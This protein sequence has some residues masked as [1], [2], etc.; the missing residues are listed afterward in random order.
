MCPVSLPLRSSLLVLV[1]FLFVVSPARAAAASVPRST[2]CWRVE[3]LRRGM[4]GH[5]RTVMKGTRVE[6]FQVEVLGVL[7]NTSPGRDLV[8]A[9]LSGLGLEKTGVIAG[10]SGSPV[11]IEGKLLGAVAY[12]WPFGKEPIAGITPFGQMQGFVEALQRSDVAGRG[13]GPVRVGL[14]ERLRAGGKEFSAVTVAQDHDEPA[15]RDDDALLLRPLRSPLVAS[16]FGPAALKLLAREAGKF[17][18]V[19]MQGGSASARIADE[20][21]DAVLEPGGPLAVSLIT[22]DFDL[23]GI[24]TVTHV[25]GNRVYGWGHPFMSLGDCGLPMMTGYIHTIYPRQTVSFKM[26]SPLREVGVMHADVSTCIA[27]AT[28][29]KADLLPVHMSVT[30]GK[31]DPRTF[32]VQVARHSALLPS[33]VFTSLVNCIDL[34]GELPDE[35]TAHLAARIEVEGAAPIVIEDT[36]SGFSGARAPAVVYSPVA[37]TVSYLTNNPHRTLRIKRI[38]CT[39]RLEAGRQTAEI[40]AVELDSQTYRPGDTVRATV[41]LKPYKGDYRRVRVSL[42]LPSDLPEGDYT[43][44]VCDEPT[45]ARSDVRADPTLLFPANVEQVLEGLRVQTRAK[46]TTLALRLPL[47]AHGVAAGG[48]ALPRLP[49]SMV[50]MLAN[51]RRTGAQAMTR[52]LVA[53][54]DTQWVIQGSEQVKFTVSKTRKVTRNED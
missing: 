20:E 40:E 2:P 36:L 45:S 19:P 26:G 28:G 37:S 10:M 25:E 6:T 21:K 27:G 11:Y 7:R 48:K 8:L 3:D 34:E 49:G 9:R 23:S 18:L 24:G 43:A 16:G 31:D 4:K 14:G 52:A 30:M 22:G 17:G 46:R 5:G 50:H 38:D 33:L 42:D 47:G 41:S 51:A 12:A 44:T 13:R 54:Q 15:P 35:L 1:G 29:K 32:R 39:T 53:R